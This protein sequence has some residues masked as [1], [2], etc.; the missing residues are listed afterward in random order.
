MMIVSIVKL[1]QLLNYRLVSLLSN[2]SLVSVQLS[3]CTVVAMDVLVVAQRNTHFLYFSSRMSHLCNMISYDIQMAF[4]DCFVK[5]NIE[6][7]QNT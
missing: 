3:I 4:F 7:A 6:E 5:C 1:L 2:M